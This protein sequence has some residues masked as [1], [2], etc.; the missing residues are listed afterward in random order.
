MVRAPNTTDSVAKPRDFPRHQERRPAER[1][2]GPK[3]PSSTPT[4]EDEEAGE[5][6][7]LQQEAV[8]LGALKKAAR[9]LPNVL[10][11][12]RLFL[13]PLIV[14]LFLQ[15]RYLPGLALF[16][17]ACAT[18]FLDGYLARRFQW[19]TPL[20]AVLDPIADKVFAL[21]FFTLLMVLGSCPAWFLGLWI[22]VNL[23]QCLGFVLI[24]MNHQGEAR[25]LST[26]RSAKWNTGIQ[27]IWIGMVFCDFFLRHRFPH[28]FRFSLPFHLT[29]YF[30]LAAS[31]VVVFFRYFHHYRSSLV[32]DLRLDFGRRPATE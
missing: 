31:Q 3:G 18:D 15:G 17:L 32:P 27:F 28:N 23:L 11:I 24:R 30:L 8:V 2:G 29:G 25:S 21:S 22:S 20:G 19:M 14:F 10:T 12:S 5:K 4:T 26:L 6:T 16:V 9:F 1:G 7:R 13:C